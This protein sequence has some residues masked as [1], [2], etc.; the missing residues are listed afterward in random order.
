MIERLFPLKWDAIISLRP[1]NNI[2][3][4][5]CGMR[6]SAFIQD[7][8]KIKVNLGFFKKDMVFSISLLL[9]IISC[10][11]QPPKLAYINF[12]VLISLFNLMVVIKVFEELRVMDKLAVN[13][14]NKCQNGRSV[15]MV[16]ILLCF[17]SSMFF[18]NDV[19]LLTFIPL[20]LLIGTKTNL[21]MMETVIFQTI[22]ANIAQP[23]ANGKS[24]KLI[25]LFLFWHS[26]HSLFYNSPITGYSWGQFVYCV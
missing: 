9:A 13:L 25:H 26:T 17:F 10:F 6:E 22:A 14:L 18:T 23:Y 19:A 2:D 11:I 20:S 24:A 21:P 12:H 8:Q 15:S 7:K 16:L 1:F 4:R 3:V 5:W